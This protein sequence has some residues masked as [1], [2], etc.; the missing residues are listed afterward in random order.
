MRD[1][2]DAYRAS[3]MNAATGDADVF[4][5]DSSTSGTGLHL[6]SSLGLRLQSTSDGLNGGN[7]LDSF[8][9]G[10]S[11]NGSYR[12]VLEGEE[13]LSYALGSAARTG[14]GLVYDGLTGAGDFQKAG[15]SWR[16]GDYGTAVAFGM[17]GVGTAGMTVL[18]GAEYALA[19]ASVAGSTGL[20]ATGEAAANGAL[21]GG[22]AFDGTLYRAVGAG[23]DPLLIHAGNIANSHRY[24]GPG[25]GGLYFATGEHVVEAEFVNNGGTL[26]G[27]Q[28]HAFPNTSVSNLLDV[29]NA[30]VRNSLGITLEDLTRTGGTQAWR[31]EVTQP[32]GSW[33]QQN[34]YKGIIAP[35]AQANGGVNLILFDAKGVK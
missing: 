32:L 11:S 12:S 10:W 3:G 17:R 27:T 5:G 15:Q 34:G 18:G 4:I 1:M 35:S 29:S 25:Q 24:T 33:A 6:G 19:K 26:A 16:Q 9:R 8:S 28:M 30:T 2:T 14:L 23:Y 13:P 7:A 31:Y 22:A 21:P 20:R